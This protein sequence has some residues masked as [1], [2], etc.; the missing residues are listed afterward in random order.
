VAYLTRE[1]GKHL[2][3]PTYKILQDYNITELYFSGYGAFSVWRGIKEAQAL[4]YSDITLISNAFGGVIHKYRESIFGK[5]RS[6]YFQKLREK[7]VQVKTSTELTNDANKL[8]GRNKKFEKRYPSCMSSKKISEP[9]RALV[10]LDLQEGFISS[11]NHP[12]TVSNTM[13]PDSHRLVPR[14]NAFLEWSLRHKNFFSQIHFSQASHTSNNMPLGDLEYP[15][16]K[17]LVTDMASAPQ[18]RGNTDTIFSS[19]GKSSFFSGKLSRVI[20]GSNSK[21]LR[22]PK[23]LSALATLRTRG[24]TQLYLAGAALD[25]TVIATAREAR[26]QGFSV[27]ILTDLT[28]ARNEKLREGIPRESLMRYY[29]NLADNENIFSLKSTDLSEEYFAN[30]GVYIPFSDWM[31]KNGC[32]KKENVEKFR[33]TL[34]GK[35]PIIRLYLILLIL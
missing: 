8:S 23:H 9:R 12:Y 10:V 14:I 3:K 28:Q 30:E 19:R 17:D 15:L 26:S 2:Q 25:D 16:V 21:K 13:I 11:C 22:Y 18:Y 27:Y 5:N 29:Y 35:V 32:I 7:K 6:E 4:G 24:I 34:Q 20:L 31:E 1:N 33:D